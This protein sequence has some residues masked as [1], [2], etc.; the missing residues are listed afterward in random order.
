MTTEIQRSAFPLDRHRWSWPLTE[1]PL[2]CSSSP[3]GA[4]EPREAKLCWP[5]LVPSPWPQTRGGSESLLPPLQEDIWNSLRIFFF[6]ATQRSEVP[7]KPPKCIVSLLNKISSHHSKKTYYESIN[8]E[9]ILFQFFYACR[10][11]AVKKNQQ[12][13]EKKAFS[14]MGRIS[15]SQPR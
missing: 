8:P 9:W 5:Q 2:S 10:N 4:L 15:A 6:N 14:R 7:L 11:N 12:K 3:P 13:L 1:S